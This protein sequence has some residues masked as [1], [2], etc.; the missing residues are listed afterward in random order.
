MVSRKSG[1]SNVPRMVAFFALCTSLA[2]S[3]CGGTSGSGSVGT[4]P[5]ATPAAA[6]ADPITFSAGNVS[7]SQGSGSVSLTVTR[8]GTATNAVTVDF[9]TNDGTAA[10]G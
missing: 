5:A 8:S 7:V 4:T 10:G 1:T 9:A 6:T 2:L 3:G